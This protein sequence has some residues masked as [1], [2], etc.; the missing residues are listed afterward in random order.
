MAVVRSFATVAALTTI[1]ATAMSVQASELGRRYLAVDQSLHGAGTTLNFTMGQASSPTEIFKADQAWEVSNSL[2]L[3]WLNSIVKGPDNVY[4]MYY[5][6]S[7]DRLALATSTDGISWTRHVTN[8]EFAGSNLLTLDG[9]TVK[10]SFNSVFYDQQAGN[11][12]LLWSSGNQMHLAQSTNGLNFTT[13]NNNAFTTKTDT[14]HVA[15]YDTVANEYRI[16]GRKRGDWSSGDQ[17][18]R[19]IPLHR[20]STWSST[21]WTNVNQTVADPAQIWNYTTHPNSIADYPHGAGPDLYSPSV[22]NYHGQYIGLPSVFHRDPSRVPHTRPNRVT[23]PVYP[24]VMHSLDG[25]NWNM[26]HLSHPIIDLSPYERVNQWQYATNKT[27]AEVGQIYTAGNFIEVGDE[28]FIFYKWRDDTHYEAGTNDFPN[29]HYDPQTD[30]GIA[31]QKLRVDGFASMKSSGPAGEWHTGNVVV[32]VGARGLLINA[33][34][35]GS[36]Q[37]EVRDTGGNVIGNLSLANSIAFQGDETSELMQW[38]AGQFAQVAG[39][40]VQLRFV[41]EDGEIYSFAFT[42]I[43]EPA[44][45]AL[46]GLGGAMLLRRKRA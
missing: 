35:E 25:E 16:Y 18:R 13:V 42:T 46:L 1:L 43:P 31:M 2:R 24:M 4:R 14:L 26:P 45:L 10:D 7:G 41:V 3:R 23:G 27:T 12:K 9:G 32:P 5:G 37:V 30:Q 40:T 33:D 28:L 11:Y 17:D 6:V 29:P 36:L 8:N 39:Q 22:Q 19:G 20:S 44:S 34:V 38:S 15:F 21:N